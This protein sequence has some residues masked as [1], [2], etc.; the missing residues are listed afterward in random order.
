MERKAEIGK[1]KAVRKGV[2]FVEEW[3]DRG[4]ETYRFKIPRYCYVVSEVIYL[5]VDSLP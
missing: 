2:F 1:R 3:D 4:S 5:M